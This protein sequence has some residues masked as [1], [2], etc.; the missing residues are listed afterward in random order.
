MLIYRETQ[1]PA[2]NLYSL[3]SC[4]FMCCRG[5]LGGGIYCWNSEVSISLF[6]G[7]FLN[8]SSTKS[9]LI[10][11]RDTGGASGAAMFAYCANAEM[12]RVCVTECVSPVSA[13]YV[14]TVSHG[15]MRVNNVN[16]YDDDCAG[17]HTDY[18]NISATNTN[19]TKLVEF[20]IAPCCQHHSEAKTYYSH[21]N[22]ENI[23]RDFAI[24]L[25]SY[26][27]VAYA[28]HCNFIDLDRAYSIV[29]AWNSVSYIYY[30]YFSNVCER[31]YAPHNGGSTQVFNSTEA[32]AVFTVDCR[33]P[34]MEFTKQVLS[35]AW[36]LT[37]LVEFL[38]IA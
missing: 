38:F 12:E 19:Y 25:Q 32:P 33:C 34:T 6:D 31:V 22:L 29:S 18:V 15:K 30:S 9:T 36:I 7:L 23:T 17:I 11:I 27:N 20:G 21:M 16:V 4:L 24:L 13:I 35:S 1:V 14:Q 37:L 5:E 3:V 26:Y 2:V 8:C 28:Y 10:G